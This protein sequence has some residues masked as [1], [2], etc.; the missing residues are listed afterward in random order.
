MDIKSIVNRMN[1]AAGIELTT[2]E[3]IRAG[4]VMIGSYVF[5]GRIEKGLMPAGRSL[6]GNA[7]SFWFRLWVASKI[8]D[9]YVED[10][11]HLNKHTNRRKR[12]QVAEGGDGIRWSEEEK[13]Q[14]ETKNASGQMDIMDWLNE[15]DKKKEGDHGEE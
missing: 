7:F 4:A 14:E 1:E 8:G 5:L 9:I 11:D 13:R 3:W 10:A 15:K 12:K 6:I 2:S